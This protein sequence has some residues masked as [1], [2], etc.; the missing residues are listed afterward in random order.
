MKLILGIVDIEPEN[1]TTGPCMVRP[2]KVVGL[3]FSVHFSA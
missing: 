1:I 3:L 2:L